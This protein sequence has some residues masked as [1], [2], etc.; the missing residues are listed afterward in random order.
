[1]AAGGVEL[2]AKPDPSTDVPRRGLALWLRADQGVTQGAGTV[3][4]WL[5]RSGNS[6]HAV[7]AV[8]IHQPTFV[9]NAIQGRPALRFDGV[10]DCLTFPCPVTGLP[11]MTIF[12]V[13]AVVEERT[14]EPYGAG[15]AAIYWKEMEPCGGVVVAPRPTKVNVYFGTGQGQDIFRTF[16]GMS[17]DR[18]YSLT[19]ALKSGSDAVVFVN[20]RESLRVGGQNPAIAQCE[21]IGQLGRGEGDQGQIEGWTYF[22]GEIA[23]VI[24]YT[25][26]L[27]ESERTS[28]EQYLLS[29]YF[30]K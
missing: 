7:Q 9:P 6:R 28:V 19:T 10:D 22:S 23:E 26:A 1:V 24:V 11:G 13:A 30:P 5:D 16:R 18:G 17:L 8:R 29:K 2:T 15:K 21:K 20:G 25:R 12:L 3:S 27:G 14:G 4:K